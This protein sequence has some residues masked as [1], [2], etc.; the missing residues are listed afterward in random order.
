MRRSAYRIASGL[1]A[2]LLAMLTATLSASPA[3]AG[4]PFQSPDTGLV[5]YSSYPTGVVGR[6]ATP[7]GVCRQVPADATWLL[8]WNGGFQS[9]PGYRTPDC[10]GQASELNNFHSWPKGYYLTYKA[11]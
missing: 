11:S 2:A 4:E 8:A 9:V 6:Q 7:D 1:A 10:S 3:A 5:F